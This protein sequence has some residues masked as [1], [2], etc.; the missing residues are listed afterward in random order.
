MLIISPHFSTGGAP[1][2]TLNKVHLLKD[3]FDIMVVEYSF[4]SWKYVVQRNAVKALIGDSNFITLSG[5]QEDKKEALAELIE[6]FRPDVV[7]MEEFP[8]MF[9][10]EETMEMVYRY[11]RTYKV[12]ETTHDSSFSIQNKI[13]LPD[14]FIFVSAYNAIKYAHYKVPIRIVEYPVNDLSANK[15]FFMR[16]LGLDKAYKHVVIIGL[17]T[18]RKNQKYAFEIAKKLSNYN[19]KFHFVGNQAEN[20]A[21]YWEPLLEDKPEDCVLWGER[22]D[23]G[24]FIQAADLFLFPSKGD[25]GNKELNPIVIKEA[26]EYRSLPKLIF[27]LDVYLGKYNGQNDFHF[28]SG[29]SNED[30]QKVVELTKAVDMEAYINDEIIIIG[31]YPNLKKREDLTIDCIHSL[32]PLNRRIMLLSHYPVSQKIQDLVDYYIFDSHN[33]L[34]HHSYY[35]KFYNYKSD[36]DVDININGLKDSNQSLPVLTNL[37]NG[38]KAAKAYGYKK[39]FYITYDV[40]VKYEDL[41]EIEKSFLSIDETCKAYLATLPTPFGHGIQTTAMTLD[42]DRFLTSFADVRTPE[43]YNSACNKVGSQNFLEDYFVK[44]VNS[45]ESDTYKLITNEHNTFLTRSGLGVSSNSE[46]YSILPIKDRDNEFMFYFFTYNIDERKILV[47]LND[48]KERITH[49]ILVDQ[50]REYKF[51]FKYEG[52]PI[53]ITMIFYDGDLVYKTEKYEINPKTLAKFKATGSF[54]HKKRPR[55][56]LVHLQTTLGLPKEEKSKSELSQVSLHGWEYVLHNNMPYED[57]PPV[58]N[59]MRPACVSLLLFSDEE[60][61]KYGTA[62]TPAHYGCYQSFKDGILSEFDPDLDY[63]IVCEGDCKL[64]TGMDDFVSKVESV[65]NIVKDTQ[66][67]YVSFGDKYTLEHGWL[68]SPVIEEIPNQDLIYVTDHIIGLQCIMFPIRVV[69]W[70][71]DKLRT[72]NWDAADMYFNSIFRNSPFKMAIVKERLT[73]QY[74]GIS[75]IDRQ[76]KTF[77]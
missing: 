19:I 66:I 48:G 6:S 16:K 1:Q 74:D 7:S 37:Q 34:T 43:D 18:P 56:K 49:T 70:L 54:K 24:D 52:N 11:E 60:V 30:A 44:V 55:I 39:A 4:L 62:L 23:V 63:L 41:S 64:E 68:Q 27:N 8:E 5:N 51:D 33:P 42:I 36:Y 76:E 53:T 59:C 14:E 28:L 29:D 40:V 75:L 65:C 57:L 12:T 50:T 72:H 13:F 45:W 35:M 9:M 46:Y 58:R 31:T 73:S 17:F 21:Y 71:K 26:A 15:E 20:F 47:I 22:N 2:V 77:K 38:F 10:S 32:K 61:E 69:G 3:D 67:G 25:R